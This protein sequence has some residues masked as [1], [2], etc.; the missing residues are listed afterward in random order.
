M[1]AVEPW[2][3]LSTHDSLSDTIITRSTRARSFN[4]LRSGAEQLVPPPPTA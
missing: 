3:D 2:R 4:N 1:V